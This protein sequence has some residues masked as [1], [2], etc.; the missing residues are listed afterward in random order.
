MQIS[1]YVDNGPSD[2]KQTFEEGDLGDGWQEVIGKRRLMEGIFASCGIGDACV[3]HLAFTNG[4][5]EV[6][7]GESLR[8]Y[9]RLY[10][11]RNDEKAGSVF[12]K[13]I[14]ELANSGG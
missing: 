11:G 8:P 12:A 9:R 4:V 1:A 5:I 10:R 13:A 14:G 7:V 3:A 6:G 2:Q